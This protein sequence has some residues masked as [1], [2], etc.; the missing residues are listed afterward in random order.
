MQS[1]S[2]SAAGGGSTVNTV[3][4]AAVDPDAGDFA[5]RAPPVDTAVHGRQGTGCGAW[6]GGT[7]RR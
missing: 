2:P 7:L 3:S 6:R 1:S 5:H 4:L